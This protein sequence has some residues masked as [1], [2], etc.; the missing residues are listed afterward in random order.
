MLIATCCFLIGSNTSH[1]YPIPSSVGAVLEQ[2]ND[3]LVRILLAAAVV[4]FVFALYDGAEGGEARTMAFV[5]PLIIFLIL[6]VNAVVRVWQESNGE[7]A[8][9]ALKEIHSDHATV[10]RDGRWSHNLP[11]CDLVKLRVGD[12]V[13]TD[14]RMLQLIS[15]TLRVDVY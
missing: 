9:E 4:S 7:R 13:P 10:K 6:I 3:T 1:A 8:L 5:E 12:K 2:F 11:V 14:M 15:S